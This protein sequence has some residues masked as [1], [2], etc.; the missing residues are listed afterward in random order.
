GNHQVGEVARHRTF[1]ARPDLDL[2]AVPEDD[3]PEAVP[4]RF[5]ELTLRDPLD[6]LGEHR[7]DRWHH[8]KVH[9]VSLPDLPPPITEVDVSHR[10][11]CRARPSARRPS[12]WAARGAAP[13]ASWGGP[14]GSSARRDHAPGR[15]PTGR[16][17]RR[18][19]QPRRAG[20]PRRRRAPTTPPA[21][22]A[23]STRPARSGPAA[24]RSSAPTPDRPAAR[25][26]TTPRPACG[27]GL[28]G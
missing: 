6:R 11:G 28:P 4:L 1:V 9:E 15:P 25:V 7:L 13:P 2:V 16:R 22:Y 5:V 23:P 21:R 3:R 19:S 27:P 17:H 18:S 8:G 24:P 10:P 12:C 20:A 26:A 14:A